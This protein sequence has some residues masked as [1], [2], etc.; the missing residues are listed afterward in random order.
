MSTPSEHAMS[1]ITAWMTKSR[2]LMDIAKPP[3]PTI[4][5]LATYSAR[6]NVTLHGITSDY[7]AMKDVA[8]ELALIA[9]TVI[10]L[11]ADSQG[12]P[13]L[14]VLQDIAASQSPVSSSD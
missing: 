6:P 12:L 7:D 2:E 3:S 8:I 1:M 14:I 4:D 10:T 11:W 5:R 9:A 13:P